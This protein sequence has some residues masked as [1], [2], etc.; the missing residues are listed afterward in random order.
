MDLRPIGSSVLKGGALV[1]RY[2]VICGPQRGPV[3]VY[4]L[5]PC[6]HLVGRDLLGN[7][8]VCTM[9]TP[10][11]RA[12][13]SIQCEFVGIRPQLNFSSSV[14]MFLDNGLSGKVSA[15][16]HTGT[17]RSHCGTGCLAMR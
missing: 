1:G 13:C 16:K 2:L 12:R 3:S 14:A 8:N 4:L 17:Q 5:T 10:T 11:S 9:S 7:R 6:Q 15:G